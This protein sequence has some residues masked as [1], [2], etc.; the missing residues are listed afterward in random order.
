MGELPELS[1]R[2]RCVLDLDR[3]APALEFEQRWYP[4]DAPASAAD[5]VAPR[6]APGERVAVLLRNRP[7]HVTV[8]RLP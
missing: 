2:I 3:S 4:W 6:V 1:R 8:I 5:T 7:P